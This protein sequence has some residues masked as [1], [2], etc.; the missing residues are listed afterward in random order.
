MRDHHCTPDLCLL[1]QQLPRTYTRGLMVRPQPSALLPHAGQ[2]TAVEIPQERR[3]IRERPSRSSSW[4]THMGT[5][6]T[7]SFPW[8][9]PTGQAP[10]LHLTRPGTASRKALRIRA[11]GSV[12][13]GF[14]H[15]PQGY[16]RGGGAPSKEWGNAAVGDALGDSCLLPSS[17]LGPDPAVCSATHLG[18]LP[19]NGHPT[20]LLVCSREAHQG[21]A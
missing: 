4:V 6:N 2:S 20:H 3:V 8:E 21:R 10:A 17:A 12:S 18:L 15:I 7:A 9:S 14:P 5:A 16:P 13:L 1:L 11:E 19:C